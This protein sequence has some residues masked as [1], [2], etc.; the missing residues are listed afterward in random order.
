MSNVYPFPNRRALHL[1]GST[2]AKTFNHKA[3]N[4]LISELEA[5][6]RTPQ[7]LSSHT[8]EALNYAIGRALVDRARTNSGLR[9]GV[10]D[11][12]IATLKDMLLLET[13]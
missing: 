7:T 11:R 4:S 9:I 2:E 6:P 3:F 1:V 13:I 8:T 5:Y 10:I 12:H